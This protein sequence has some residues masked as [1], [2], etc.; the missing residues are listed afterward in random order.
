MLAFEFLQ[1]FIYFVG[2]VELVHFD[3]LIIMALH[4]LVAIIKPRLFDAGP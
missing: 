2:Q 4:V 1:A 3:V